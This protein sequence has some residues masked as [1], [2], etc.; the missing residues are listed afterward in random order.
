VTR[1]QVFFSPPSK[2]EVSLEQ[3]GKEHTSIDFS[4]LTI[5]PRLKIKAPL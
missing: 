1:K 2:T 5:N 3:G 4:V